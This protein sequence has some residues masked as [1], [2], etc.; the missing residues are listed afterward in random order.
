[1]NTDLNLWG[2]GLAIIEIYISIF[3]IITNILNDVM[4][5]YNISF[6][7]QKALKKNSSKIPILTEVQLKTTKIILP[8]I[9]FMW[10]NILYLSITDCIL[11]NFKINGSYYTYKLALNRENLFSE[12]YNTMKSGKKKKKKKEKKKPN[13]EISNDNKNNNESI[14]I[15]N[16]ENILLII[17]LTYKIALIH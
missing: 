9:V 11:I 6:Y 3:G 7:Q 15:L 16:N 1:M 13:I 10:I 17:I 2:F 5:F 8:I 14:T 4:I 12:E